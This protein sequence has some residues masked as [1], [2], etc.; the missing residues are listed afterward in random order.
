VTHPNLLGHGQDGALAF[1]WKIY[2][3]DSLHLQ[4]FGSH[5][6]NQI[7]FGYRVNRSLTSRD[8][9]LRDP[10]TFVERFYPLIHRQLCCI[11]RMLM[12][13]I[14]CN[15]SS[16]PTFVN[17]HTTTPHAGLFPFARHVIY[18]CDLGGYRFEDG[19]TLTTIRCSA[20]G[21]TWSSIITSCK[22]MLTLCISMCCKC[23]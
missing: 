4:H 14:R 19:R 13:A 6:K 11:P 9:G 20:T 22:R 17:A 15:G 2:R 8:L 12:T 10:S 18:A 5:K 23:T 21:W 16:L 1:R 3:L 7:A